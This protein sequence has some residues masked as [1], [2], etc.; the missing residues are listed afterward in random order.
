MATT[1]PRLQ[2]LATAWA[3]PDDPAII[4]DLAKASGLLQTAEVLRANGGITH[5][6]K[7]HNSIPSAAFRNIGEGSI[8]SAVSID[9]KK[10][11]LW[12]LESKAEAD[13]MFVDNY[14]GGK[15]GWLMD[16]M[17]A[18][19]EGMGQAISKQA[20]YGGTSFAASAK[21]FL[22]LHAY[23]KALSNVVGQLGGASASRTSIFCVRWDG[24]D[25]AN[26]RVNQAGDLINVKDLTPTN[27]V[28]VVTDTT[29]NTQLTAYQW[30]L[31]AF[32]TLIVPGKKSVGVLTQIDSTHKPTVDYMNKLVKSVYSPTGRKVIYCNLDGLTYIESLKDT[33]LNMFTESNDYDTALGYWAGVP[34]IVDENILSTETTD[35]D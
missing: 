35:L 3:V 19:L 6:F 2:G 32:F 7:M 11:D 8:P 15:D 21:G 24:N 13:Y 14:P 1:T 17:G 18:Y 22:G 29:T 5:T 16:N 33:K 27:P 26:L 25:G 10:I 4:V 34:I 9:A 23:A 20:F 12:P 28:T 30:L 31:N